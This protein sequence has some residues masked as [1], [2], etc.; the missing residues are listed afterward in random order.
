[1]EKISV[2][3]SVYNEE[4]N[5]LEEA[6]ESILNQ[7]YKNL[8][9][10]IVLDK[11]TSTKYE[12]NANDNIEYNRNMLIRSKILVAIFLIFGRNAARKVN[13]YIEKIHI[14]KVNL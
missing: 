9:F 12:Q 6:I 3:M 11:P 1:M 7:T 14:W 5:I 8:E 4:I 2:V 13:D 10:I